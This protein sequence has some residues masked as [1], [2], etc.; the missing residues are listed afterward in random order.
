MATASRDEPEASDVRFLALP[1]CRASLTTSP[2]SLA[3][4]VFLLVGDP[5]SW[6]QRVPVA[7][8]D[9]RTLQH[10]SYQF[11]LGLLRPN[12]CEA[13]LKRRRAHL[14]QGSDEVLQLAL[15]F[16]TMLRAKSQWTNPAVVLLRSWC[17]GWTTERR[18]QQNAGCALGCNV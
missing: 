5:H 11:L 14:S 9:P 15:N 3:F 13:T 2:M 10:S 16:L 8:A 1:S 7:V 18:F 17:N 12:C 4:L 6:P